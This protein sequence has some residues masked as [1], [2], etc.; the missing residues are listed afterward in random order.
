ME[1]RVTRPCIVFYLGAVAHIERTEIYAT[2]KINATGNQGT[3]RV[4]QIKFGS[5]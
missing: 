2:G 5:K 1:M 3:T 4:Q